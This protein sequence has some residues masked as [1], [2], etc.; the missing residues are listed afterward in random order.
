MGDQGYDD[1]FDDGLFQTSLHASARCRPTQWPRSTSEMRGYTDYGF[2]GMPE[3]HDTGYSDYMSRRPYNAVNTVNNAYA[4]PPAVFQVPFWHDHSNP[5]N[6]QWAGG[7]HG[8]PHRSASHCSGY[9]WLDMG[10][11]R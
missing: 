6:R 7:Y 4:T 5:K 8:A 1:Q 11:T 10:H 9:R 3:G 2:G